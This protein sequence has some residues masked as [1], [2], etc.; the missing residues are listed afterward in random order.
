MV[1]AGRL[2]AAP[3]APNNHFRTVKNYRYFNILLAA[4]K[5]RDNTEM[6]FAARR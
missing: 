6:H 3:N 5:L 4:E 1:S 2:I